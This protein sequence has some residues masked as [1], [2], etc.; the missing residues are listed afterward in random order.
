MHENG[1]CIATMRS[2]GVASAVDGAYVARG[3]APR[4]TGCNYK[5][6]RSSHMHLEAIEH[7]AAKDAASDGGKPQDPLAQVVNDG[8][9]SE[10]QCLIHEVKGAEI[11]HAKPLVRF[12]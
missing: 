3:S 2:R 9:V 8:G 6:V 1:T 4:A 10:P 7:A 5:P 11:A 12:I